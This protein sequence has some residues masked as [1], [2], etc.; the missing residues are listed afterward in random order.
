MSLI[1]PG[2]RS[3]GGS[4][5]G[6]LAMLAVG[7]EIRAVK[8]C[9]VVMVTEDQ[10]VFCIVVFGL[11]REVETAGN[12]RLLIDHHYLVVG[13]GMAGIDPYFNSVILQ[14]AQSRVRFFFVRTVQQHDDLDSPSSSFNQGFAN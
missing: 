3:A 6:S 10:Q 5:A 11:P 8:N 9:Q 14:V 4:L 12:N 1:R 7:M 13:N 2:L